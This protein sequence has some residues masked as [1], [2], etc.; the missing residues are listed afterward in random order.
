MK[1]KNFVITQENI[2]IFEMSVDFKTFF[3]HTI[4]KC[5]EF[6]TLEEFKELLE[7]VEKTST[8][9]DFFPIFAKDER[10][11]NIFVTY[12]KICKGIDNFKKRGAFSKEFIKF[13]DREIIED[14]YYMYLQRHILIIRNEALQ[15]LYRKIGGTAGGK[16]CGPVTQKLIE[17]KANNEKE[18]KVPFYRRLILQPCGWALLFALVF[19]YFTKIH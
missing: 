17:F 14:E 16:G 1:T 9:S 15:E 8:K 6:I 2:A 11:K 12:D 5:Q 18:I 7:K 10:S 3:E 4:L 13:F 19:L